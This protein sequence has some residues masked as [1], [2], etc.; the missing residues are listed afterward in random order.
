M[1]NDENAEM[2]KTNPDHHTKD[3]YDSIE[4]G[5]HPSWTL[6]V[7]LMPEKDE[8]AYKY[9]SFDTTKVW[10]HKDYPLI[11]VG[12]MTLNRN[13]ENYHAEVEQSAFSPS[14]FVPG[15][16]PSNDKMLQG[17]LFSY[18]GAQRHRLGGNYQQIP[19]NCPYRAK[20]VNEYRDG[21]VTTGNQGKQ[22]N[23]EPNSHGG[24][25]QDSSVA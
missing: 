18:P 20:V 11:K 10:S 7:Q 14:N 24:P 25:T 3:L 13:P 9:D 16:E 22:E 6:Y 23:Y 1:T 12:K 17:R 8:A 19:I 5:D 4:N 21:I 15:I 2:A